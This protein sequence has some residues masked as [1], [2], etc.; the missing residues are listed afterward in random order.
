MEGDGRGLFQDT[1][2]TFAGKTGK[3]VNR[4]QG[5]PVSGRTSHQVPHVYKF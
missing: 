3:H 4:Q 1:V 5:E 2:T